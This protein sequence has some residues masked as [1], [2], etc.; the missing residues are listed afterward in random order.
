MEACLA[1]GPAPNSFH[2]ANNPATLM[3]LLD[4]TSV[5]AG[6]TARWL[7]RPG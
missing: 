5:L 1:T 6:A 7:P 3:T 2:A 4:R